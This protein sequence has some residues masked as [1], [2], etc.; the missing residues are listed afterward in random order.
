MARDIRRRPPRSV[1]RRGRSGEQE[2][3]KDNVRFPPARRPVQVQA[4]RDPAGRD[5][6]REQ[7]S[8]S[9][10][11]TCWHSFVAEGR[12]WPCSHLSITLG[13]FEDL[14]SGNM[15]IDGFVLAGRSGTSADDSANASDEHPA[16]KRKRPSLDAE[17]R[18]RR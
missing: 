8:W 15:G 3:A 9:S 2:T 5:R 12:A 17:D 14:I 18:N 10:Q 16:G 7:S 13:G 4:M 11:S 6:N 1:F